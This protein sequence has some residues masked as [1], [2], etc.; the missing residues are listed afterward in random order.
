MKVLAITPELPTA[1]D[2]GSMAPAARQLQALRDVGMD[3]ITQDM[4]GIPKLKYLQ[5]I[6]RMRSQ[7]KNVDLI[8]AHF[9]I[10]SIGPTPTRSLT[11]EACS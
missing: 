10:R 3:I 1:N 5:V 8:H 7:L 2:P 11:E 9:G 4:R 6:P